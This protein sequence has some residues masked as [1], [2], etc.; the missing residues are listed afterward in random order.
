MMKRIALITLIALTMLA[1]FTAN[2]TQLSAKSPETAGKASTAAGETM[3]TASQLYEQG[4][5]A[6]AGQAYQQL[7]D[8]GFADH[9]LFYNL[10]N[11]YF[12][13]GEIG[14]AILNYRRA[15]LL[16]PRD[17]DIEANL[18]LALAQTADQ[19]ESADNGG[20]FSRLGRSVQGWFTVN[21]LAMATLGLWILFVFLMILFNGT[22]TGSTWRRGLQY[23]LVV[24]AIVLAVGVVALG[25]SLYVTNNLSEGIVVAE[26]VDVTSG[27]GSQYVTEFALH[28]GAE[29]DLLE[30]RGNWVRL[31]LPG[32]ELEGWA[33]ASAVESITG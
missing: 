5:F 7:V 27:P 26:Q 17:P 30:T 12:K 19:L 28:S 15:Q 4:Q 23:A 6:Q 14:R 25:S 22:R 16:A 13:Q 9:A 20:F 3:L 24:T 21:E 31:A 33:P 18:N 1:L 29:V 32:G 8:Q 2:Q 11:A 10:G